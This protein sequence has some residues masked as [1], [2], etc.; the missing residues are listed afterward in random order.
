MKDSYTLECQE[1][2][3][4]TKDRNFQDNYKYIFKDLKFCMTQLWM[5]LNFIELK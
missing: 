1:V 2:A 5:T 3:K 4:Y